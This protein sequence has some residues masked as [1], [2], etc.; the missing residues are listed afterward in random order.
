MK[1]ELDEAFCKEF[2]SI[3]RD[4]GGDMR[5][6]CMAWGISVNDGWEVLIRNICLFID[7]ALENVR[8]RII[9]EYKDKHKINYMEDLSPEILKELK[10]DE[11]I[12]VA[13]QVKEK[14]GTLCFYWH[15][16]NLPEEWHYRIDGAISMAEMLS[17]HVCEICGNPGKLRG[18]GWLFTACDEHS[19]GVKTLKEYQDW[20]DQ[21]DKAEKSK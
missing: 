11:I 20:E 18:P 3:F 6:T 17:A 8:N 21:K 16:E 10:L 12:V 7:N 2:P 1:Q 4:Y 15:G 19:R 5:V 13:D 9:H 14:Y